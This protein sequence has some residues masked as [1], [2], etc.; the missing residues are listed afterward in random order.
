MADPI[1]DLLISKRLLQVD[2]VDAGFEFVATP[3][4]WGDDSRQ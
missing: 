4:R 1:R 2:V 3:P